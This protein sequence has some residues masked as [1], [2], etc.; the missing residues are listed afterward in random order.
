M[1]YLV[2]L[3][4]I[5]SVYGQIVERQIL[6]STTDI[7]INGNNVAHFVYRDVN[8]QPLNKLLIFIPGTNAKPWDYRLFQQT[9]A[10]LGYH[11]I[12]LSYENLQSIN[13]ELC[14]A[15]RDPNCHANA[16]SEVW[17][18]ENTHNVL[19]INPSNSIINRLTKL[20]LYLSRNFPTENW[21]QYLLNNEVNWQL[22]V[23]SGHS[24]GAGHAAYGSKFFNVSRVIMISWVD[25]M[26]PGTNPPWVTTKG[27]TPDSAYFGF[28]HT[29]DASIYN[30]IPTTWTNLGMN[31]FGSIT[32]VDNT[33]TPYNNTHS[34]ITSA[35]ID[36]TSTETN[37][38]N[39]TVVDWVTTMNR[40]TRK[41]LYQSV[42]EYL[43][44]GTGN[45][46]TPPSNATNPQA[47]KISLNGVSW[48]DPEI[49][50]IHHKMTFQVG[51]SGNIWVG[52]LN[53]LTG[54]FVNSGTDLL[55][56]NGATSLTTSINGPEFGISKNRWS[57]FYTKA[58]AGVPQ[59]WRAIINGSTVTKTPLMS[60]N[61][62]RLS[63]LVTKDTTSNT[64]KLLYG[65]GA[66][67]NN[68]QLAWIDENSTSN[69]TIVDSLDN[70]VRWINNTQSMVYT[71]QTGANKGQL[72][73]YNT[74]TKA[75]IIITNDRDRKT[76]SYGWIAPEHGELV[77]LSVINDT[78]MGLYKNNG[79]AYWDRI[80]TMPMPPS[81]YPFRYI[82]SPEPFVANG[83][84]YVSFVL[85]AT[86][87]T[88]SYV[89]A[90]VWVMDFETNINKRFML[91]C[92]DGATNTRRTDPESY[93]GS[94][95][96][97]IYYNV[98]NAQGEFEIWRFATGIPTINTS[99][100]SSEDKI[101][102]H[103]N[104]TVFPN[105]T[106]NTIFLDIKK[107]YKSIDIA[108]YN[109]LG[110]MINIFPYQQHDRKILDLSQLQSSIYLIIVNIDG[111]I[112]TQKILKE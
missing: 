80:L 56:D 9:A 72:A 57:I 87:N 7:N 6:P 8:V 58:N 84:S 92:D 109:N 29:G 67:L 12:G 65:K 16:R 90:E 75:E 111:Q 74:I 62:P 41:P 54:N 38:H 108:L 3:L 4:A 34:L 66:T 110:Q 27:K 60:G 31:V 33:T 100:T 50:N 28:I 68:S 96:V 69:E 104:I 20:L 51:G 89:E 5:Q 11:S 81:A 91:R 36:T 42:W 88:T 23:L 45:M 71:K 112:F 78:L 2:A 35:P 86:N 46:N 13:V 70:G 73:I 17:F 95:E 32:S 98:I 21:G 49:L 99:I 10:S 26:F 61:I 22:I 106:N 30:G 97:F 107:Q 18:G 15:T 59:P 85:K 14:P 48:I 37:F 1:T 25:W 77:I 105:P 53:P 24:Q 47:Q 101:I 76:N 55:I 94:K 93:N 64:I 40:T 52:D 103:Q 82:N 102:D 19:Q 63:T 39:A 44:I 43:L 83:K 79:K